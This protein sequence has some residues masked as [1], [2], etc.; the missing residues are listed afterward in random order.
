[1]EIKLRLSF[2]CFPGIIVN[3]SSND[4]AEN[5]FD[6][7]FL[8]RL[9]SIQ[10]IYFSIEEGSMMSSSESSISN[11]LR[12]RGQTAS[13]ETVQVVVDVEVVVHVHV[14]KNRFSGTN[15]MDGCMSAIIALF[16]YGYKPL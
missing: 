16:G 13:A 3:L 4:S 15:F 8:V 12:R 10:L 1:L 2:T 7:I 6:I 14:Q 9:S 5:T 11:L